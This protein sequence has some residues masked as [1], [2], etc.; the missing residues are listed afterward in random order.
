[1]NSSSPSEIGSSATTER[2][3][4][5]VRP[6]PAVDDSSCMKRTL[7]RRGGRY[8]ATV[9]VVPPSKYLAL[10][11]KPIA[12]KG[13]ATIQKECSM[14]R[15]PFAILGSAMAHWFNVLL[16]NSIVSTSCFF[17]DSGLFR[18]KSA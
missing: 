12:Q 10:L 15:R 8:V 5:L 9:G 1:M 3:R 13:A 11:M 18:K 14:P 4:N 2:I 16:E 6:E 7:L 17:I